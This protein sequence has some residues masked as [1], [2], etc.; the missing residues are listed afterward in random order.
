MHTAEEWDRAYGTAELSLPIEP[1]PHVEEL[2]K[3]LPGRGLE[4]GCGEGR[5]SIWLAGRGWKMTA[6]DFS[7]VA[8]ERG[9]RIAAAHGVDVDW[10]VADVI[11]HLPVPPLDLVMI[12]YLH[13]LRDALLGVVGRASAA[14]APGGSLFVLGWDRANATKGTGGPRPPELLYD[15]DEL[16]AAAT[17]LRVERAERVRQAGSDR[18]VDA[19][20]RATR[21]A[22]KR[23]GLVGT[24]YQPL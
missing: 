13:I 19:L 11:G 21:P 15:L 10:Q 20:L 22:S 9:R 16:A 23:P 2:G 6:V 12:V 18:A 14:L 7:G 24:E 3:L 8:V 1:H 17:G 4:L 5:P